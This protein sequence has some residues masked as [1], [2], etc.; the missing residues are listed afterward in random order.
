MLTFANLCLT[1]VSSSIP[2]ALDLGQLYLYDLEGGL[3]V[4]PRPGPGEDHLLL[5]LRLNIR[6]V[7]DT[8]VCRRQPS[9]GVGILSM[10]YDFPIH[11]FYRIFTP[12]EV[13]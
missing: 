5:S 9:A 1:I 10:F 7:T 4:V 11:K 2:V 12:D 8:I 6:R 3:V 13:M